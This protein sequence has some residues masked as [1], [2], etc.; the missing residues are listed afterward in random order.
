M[1]DPTNW[2]PILAQMTFGAA[3]S[4]VSLYA[5]MILAG[6]QQDRAS[7][8]RQS[9]A[10][11]ALLEDLNRIDEELSAIK[12]KG[13]RPWDGTMRIAT[14]TIHPWV[15]GLIA[16]SA[17]EAPEVVA[18]FMR[19]QRAL[20]VLEDL[21]KRTG[22]AVDDVN[23]K[24]ESYVQ[25]EEH[26]QEA[27]QAEG[28]P[29]PPLSDDRIALVA[30]ASVPGAIGTHTA[31]AKLDLLDARDNEGRLLSQ[32]CYQPNAVFTIIFDLTTRLVPIAYR[33]VPGV[34]ELVMRALVTVPEDAE[35]ESLEAQRLLRSHG[36]GYLADRLRFKRA[37]GSG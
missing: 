9:G 17:E 12:E 31:R 2:A 6:T 36:F 19:L 14:P 5:G 25:L 15:E 8:K 4:L 28:Y 27:L 20:A 32:Y 10:A 7:M 35:L 22:D 26:R 1:S 18:G 3:I 29:P 24:F 21:A 33:R 30:L 16:E 23:K 13:L 37:L 34:P 11:A